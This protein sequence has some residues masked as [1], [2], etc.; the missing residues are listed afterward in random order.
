LRSVTDGRFAGISFGERNTLGL[1]LVSPLPKPSVALRSARGS[2]RLDLWCLGARSL[3]DSASGLIWQL[4]RG[5]LSS[6]DAGECGPRRCRRRR[7]RGF[8]WPMW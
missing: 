5:E 4:G 1:A 3:R 6:V 7:A 8:S 2:I